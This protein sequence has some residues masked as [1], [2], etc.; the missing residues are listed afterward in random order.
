MIG[1]Y[2]IV[3][4]APAGATDP[5][6]APLRPVQ[7]GALIALAG[8]PSPGVTPEALRAHEAVV[9]KIAEGT[10]ACLPARFGATAEDEAA[11]VRE[12][13]QRKDELTSALELVRGR[14]QMTLRVRTSAPAKKAE[15]RRSGTRYLEERK[16]A[17]EVPELDPV[18][19]RLRDFVRAEK[20]ERASEMLVSVYHL[21]DRGSAEAYARAIAAQ[22]L[23]GLQ[24]SVSGPWPAW[25]FAP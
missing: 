23:D 14:E 22:P 17:Q 1:L 25:S 20:V 6:G 4:S 15:R 19:T 5:E 3:T 9:R 18:R 13:E 24:V 2:A 16:R 11:L 21:V 8:A 12:L 7:A 10:D